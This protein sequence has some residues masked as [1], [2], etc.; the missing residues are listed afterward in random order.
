[1]ADLTVRPGQ[2]VTIH[3]CG[4]NTRGFED[5]GEVTLT[6]EQLREITHP[7]P[8]EEVRPGKYQ[9]INPRNPAQVFDTKHDFKR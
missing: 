3:V 4:D 7:E 8:V 5:C 6:Y 2:T 1:M 9:P